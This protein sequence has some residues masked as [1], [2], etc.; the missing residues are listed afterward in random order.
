MCLSGVHVG[1]G[2]LSGRHRVSLPSE[3]HRPSIGSWAGSLTSRGFLPS[4]RKS[5]RDLAASRTVCS[6]SISACTSISPSASQTASR[7]WSKKKTGG[8]ALPFAKD[9]LGSLAQ[10][11]DPAHW[12]WGGQG[13]A[14]LVLRS[15][16]D[17]PP[18]PNLG[19][20]G[21]RPGVKVLLL[22]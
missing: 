12:P 10:R 7:G 21:G 17:V 6:L 18:G 20:V 3:C 2:T 4:S 8:S 19:S 16:L 5:F 15:P 13:P 22:F 9:T 14:Y 1:R 11:E